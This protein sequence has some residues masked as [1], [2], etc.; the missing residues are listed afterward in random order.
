MSELSKVSPPEGQEEPPSQSESLTDSKP[1]ASIQKW[2]TGIMAVLGCVYFIYDR[3]RDDERR[4]QEQR[5]EQQRFAQEQERHKKMLLD[6]RGQLELLSD[7]LLLP[8]FYER[9]SKRGGVP[10]RN[11]KACS[12]PDGYS[13]RFPGAKFQELVWESQPAPTDSSE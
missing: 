7:Y 9:C 11:Q 1:W 6:L 12:M 5:Q 8:A 10:D 13:D 2:I 3:G 4:R